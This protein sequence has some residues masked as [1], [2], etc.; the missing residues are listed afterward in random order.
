MYMCWKA[1]LE[2]KESCGIDGS[3][4]A[5]QQKRSC[6]IRIATYV[7]GLHLVLDTTAQRRYNSLDNS[8]ETHKI[9]S[10]HG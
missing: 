10:R 5:V 9:A 3:T 7:K 6:V 1:L 2:V 8:L 4:C